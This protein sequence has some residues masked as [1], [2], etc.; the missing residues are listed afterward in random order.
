MLIVMEKDAT[1]DK[2]QSI[3]TAIETKGCVARTIPGGDRTSIGILHNKGSLD[4]AFFLG[5]P[6]VKE[7]I[8][9]SKPYK[10]VS[11][12]VQAEDTLVHVGDVTIGNGHFTVIAGPCAVE[13]EDQALTIA[14]HVQ[15]ARGTIHQKMYGN[16]GF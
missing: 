15:R 13:N 6:G 10:L 11:R 9:V 12:E 7:A 5:L 3:V 1:P 8:P 16:Y 14:G 2:I 4:P